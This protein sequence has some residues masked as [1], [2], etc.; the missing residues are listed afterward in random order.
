MIARLFTVGIAD[1]QELASFPWQDSTV[2]LCVVLRDSTAFL[3]S[4]EMTFPPKKVLKVDE[5]VTLEK[6]HVG[7]SLCS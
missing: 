1:S 2:T 7:E 6:V 5:R 3:A 4:S